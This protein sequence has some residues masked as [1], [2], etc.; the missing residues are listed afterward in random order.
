ML[1]LSAAPRRPHARGGC[2]GYQLRPAARACCHSKHF[3]SHA[4]GSWD[5]RT[6]ELSELGGTHQDPRVQLLALHRTPQQCQPDLAALS[7]RCWSSE[8]PGAGTLPWGAWAGP[9][10]PL[11]KNLSLTSNL[12]LPRLSCSR[13]LHSCPWAPE[14][15]GSHSP[16]QGPAPKAVA[17]ATRAGTSWDAWFPWAGVQEWDSPISCSC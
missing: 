8:S 4:P 11:G 2:H 10:Q 17:M 12:S 7:K 6:T 1:S 5:S 14:G 9:Q 3:Q 13:S 15:R 16:S